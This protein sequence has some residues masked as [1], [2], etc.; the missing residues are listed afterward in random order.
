[1]AITKEKKKAIVEKLTDIF[2]KAPSAA[3]VKFGKLTV[4]QAN[5][6]RRTLKEKGVGYFVAKKTLIRKALQ[7]KNTVG[8]LPELE[9]EVAVAYAIGAHDT[10]AP[11]R[12]VAL[13]TKRFEKA[14][15]LIGGIFE[16]AFIGQ[17]TALALSLIPSRE[18]LL[19]QFANIVNSPIQRFVIGLSEISK[20]KK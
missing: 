17:S 2:A 18:T 20:I 6:L 19:A 12:E 5:T 8:E 14:V 3:F 13:F 4:A 7:S 1:M 16:G 11:S 10:L 15:E 9:G